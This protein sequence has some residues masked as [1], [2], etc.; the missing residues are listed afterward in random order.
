[1]I[2]LITSYVDNIDW[3][4]TIAWLV[5]IA[6]VLFLCH[7]RWE[8][9][10]KEVKPAPKPKSGYNPTIVWISR[11][12]NCYHDGLCTHAVETITL[13]KALAQGYSRCSK[14]S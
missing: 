12:G 3:A 1:M 5:L 8:E 2:D 14:C 4:R 9:W 6:C 7:L 10:A 11:N 13:E